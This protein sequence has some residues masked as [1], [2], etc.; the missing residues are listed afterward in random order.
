MRAS[1]NIFHLRHCPYWCTFLWLLWRPSLGTA[2]V[3]VSTSFGRDSLLRVACWWEVPLHRAN[4]FTSAIPSIELRQFPWFSHW[5]S[6]HKM[7]ILAPIATERWNTGTW[8]R[9]RIG[10]RDW[11]RTPLW[12]T[13]WTPGSRRRLLR[14]QSMIWKKK[15]YMITK[16]TSQSSFRCQKIRW[17]AN[18]RN[19]Y[20][21]CYPQ[22]ISCLIESIKGAF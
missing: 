15:K 19:L 14:K 10:A 6:L 1:Y 17:R 11:Q 16:D 4:I 8:C 21:V 22:V 3:F 9:G 13:T 12:K 20:I 2:K 7:A 5:L 18:S